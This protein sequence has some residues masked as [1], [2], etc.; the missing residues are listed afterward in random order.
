MTPMQW[1]HLDV[2]KIGQQQI[3]CLSCHSE[4][5]N[6]IMRQMLAKLLQEEADYQRE[7][8]KDTDCG[9]TS[10]RGDSLQQLFGIAVASLVCSSQ[11][12]AT[13]V[14]EKWETWWNKSNTLNEFD[15]RTIADRFLHYIIERRAGVLEDL[16]ERLTHEHELLKLYKEAHDSSMTFLDEAVPITP[17]DNLRLE[18]KVLQ[19]DADATRMEYTDLICVHTDFG[20]STRDK[21]YGAALH[22]VKCVHKRPQILHLAERWLDWYSTIKVPN[23]YDTR[24][25]AEQFLAY[26]LARRTGIIVGHRE[27]LSFEEELAAD[28]IDIV[29]R[30]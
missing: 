18:A 3:E 2:G 10:F 4:A 20:R 21:I 8:R 24:T 27:I 12:S 28:F 25:A 6:V 14:A 9:V 23:P 22:T 30:R 5:E 1:Y 17:E 19:A 16:L 7:L 11:L 29:S 13:S 15:T 26:A